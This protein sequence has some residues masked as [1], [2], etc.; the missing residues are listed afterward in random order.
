MVGFNPRE[1]RDACGSFA[2]GV[3]VISTRTEDGDHGMTANAFM[4]VSLD[5][6]LITISL[7]RK[8][9][10]LEK[11]RSSKRYAVN[12]LSQHM[13]PLAMHFAGRHDPAL[14]EVF[15]VR[16]G[17]PVIP[18]ALAVFLTD[19][20][21][22]VEVG[23]HTLFIGRVTDI[24]RDNGNQPLLFSGGKFGKLASADE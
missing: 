4:S 18:N 17:L 22:E 15:S 12:V 21:Q 24:R 10:M 2:T 11:V 19:V 9:K 5:P 14:T 1:L 23:D 16:D 8:S 6:P 20:E 13:K 3:T 7:D